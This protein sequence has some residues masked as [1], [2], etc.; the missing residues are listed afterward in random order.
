MTSDPGSYPVTVSL[1]DQLDPN[2][3]TLT[4]SEHVFTSSN[5]QIPRVVSVAAIDDDRMERLMHT[6]SL[7]FTLTT[8]PASVYSGMSF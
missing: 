7:T 4:P 6:T 2:Q 1:S 8:D 3:V 5:W